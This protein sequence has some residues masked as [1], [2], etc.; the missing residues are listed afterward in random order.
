MVMDLTQDGVELKIEGN[1]LFLNRIIFVT[2]VW[3]KIDSINLFLRKMKIDLYI[4][5]FAFLSNQFIL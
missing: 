4:V 2:V 1:S 5:L 3:L